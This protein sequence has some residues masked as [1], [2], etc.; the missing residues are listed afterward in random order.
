MPV[1]ATAY[2]LLISAPSDVSADDI[3]H[4]TRA[5]ERWNALY[6]VGSA[7]VVIPT[8][9]ID[10]SAARYG[11]TP[12]SVLNEQLVDTADI[13][14]AIFW[15]RLGSPTGEADS[16]TIEEIVRAHER[17]AYVGILRCERPVSQD[18]ID[19]DQLRRLRE[20]FESIKGQAL[21][22]GYEDAAGLARH[23]EAILNQAVARGGA[24]LDQE[25]A[26]MSRGAAVWPRIDR[27]QFQETDNRGRLK[28]RTRWRFVLVNEGS[29]V[30]HDVSFTLEPISDDDQG[31][32]LILHE[33]DA[34]A[35]IEALGPKREI[36]YAASLHSGTSS[37]ARCVVRWSDSA[38]EHEETSTVGFQ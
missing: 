26:A 32:P 35:A 14:I 38:G 24:Q 8:T 7:A 34:A 19:L 13:V 16:G 12:Q 30:A 28:T 27:E 22:L 2:R 11:D 31:V 3:A 36:G 17:G 1:R 15:N 21:Y 23:V 5:V 9:W 20:Y 18:D 4:V 25:Q 10:H 29:E 6:G 33:S 37:Q